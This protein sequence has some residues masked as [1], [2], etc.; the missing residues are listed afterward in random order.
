[1]TI[2]ELRSTFHV[3][4]HDLGNHD[5]DFIIVDADTFLFVSVTDP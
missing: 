1:M 2:E 3:D 4:S 5:Y